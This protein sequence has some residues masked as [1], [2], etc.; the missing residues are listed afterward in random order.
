M[1]SIIKNSADKTL[2]LSVFAEYL[3]QYDIAIRERNNQI[4]EVISS[5]FKSAEIPLHVLQ[6]HVIEVLHEKM[7]D[8]CY[9][10][11][12]KLVC[13]YLITNSSNKAQDGK[14][15][16]LTRGS[17]NVPARVIRW[18]MMTEEHKLLVAEQ[19]AK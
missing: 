6:N 1:E 7:P 13:D 12:H 9:T 18:D 17:R 19:I 10:T 2:T 16:F 14:L 11:L 4:G 3:R 8:E 5:C 15:F